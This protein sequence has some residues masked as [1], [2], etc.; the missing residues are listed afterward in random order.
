M[1]TPEDP[2]KPDLPKKISKSDILFVTNFN[3]HDHKERADLRLAKTVHTVNYYTVEKREI[4]Y[5]YKKSLLAK[6]RRS[7]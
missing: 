2:A 3:L 7:L 4:W 1:K 5:H 6:S